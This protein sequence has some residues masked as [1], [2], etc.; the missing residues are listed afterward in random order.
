MGQQQGQ[1]ISLTAEI[2]LTLRLKQNLQR[3][4]SIEKIELMAESTH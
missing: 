1:S 2:G 3:C 4:L